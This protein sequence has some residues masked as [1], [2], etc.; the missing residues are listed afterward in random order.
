MSGQGESHSE[1]VD[2]CAYS[3]N[4]SRMGS[5][6]SQQSSSRLSGNTKDFNRLVV[7]KRGGVHTNTHNNEWF[8]FFCSVN[9]EMQSI[10]LPCTPMFCTF[11][12]ISKGHVSV[13]C[14]NFSSISRPTYGEK[15]NTENLSLTIFSKP[16]QPLIPNITAQRNIQRLLCCQKMR[17]SNK[18]CSNQLLRITNLTPNHEQ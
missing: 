7:S 5:S 10:S 16:S 3:S 9:D 1:K 11:S 12:F 2:I 14:F 6:L 17:S 4:S 8:L 13:L 18:S 15:I